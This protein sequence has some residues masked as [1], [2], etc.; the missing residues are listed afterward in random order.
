MARTYGLRVVS[1]APDQAQGDAVNRCS[2]MPYGGTN[3]SPGAT[4]GDRAMGH[5]G[6]LSHESFDPGDTHA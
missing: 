2:A 5:V 4:L 3:E 6:A 1:I